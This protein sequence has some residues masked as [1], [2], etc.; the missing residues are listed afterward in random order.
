MKSTVSDFKSP[1][2]ETLSQECWLILAFAGYS[3]GFCTADGQKGAVCTFNITF[4]VIF[5]YIF[6]IFIHTRVTY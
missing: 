1:Y 6:I 2:F 3:A 4:R 5:K